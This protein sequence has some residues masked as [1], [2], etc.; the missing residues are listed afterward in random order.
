M[1]LGFSH[2]CTKKK[3][4]PNKQK[5]FSVSVITFGGKLL[6]VMSLGLSVFVDDYLLPEMLSIQL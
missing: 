6:P 3:K 2:L 1:G 5:L 4:S